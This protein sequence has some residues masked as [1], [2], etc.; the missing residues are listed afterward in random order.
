M[1]LLGMPSFRSII[2]P[3]A[4]FGHDGQKMGHHHHII[5]HAVAEKRTFEFWECPPLSEL[6]DAVD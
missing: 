3:P 6:V 1:D 2:Y 4:D 5:C